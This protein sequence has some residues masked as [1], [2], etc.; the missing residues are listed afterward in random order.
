M[1]ENIKARGI[2][3][4]DMEMGKR[5]AGGVSHVTGIFNV[6]LPKREKHTEVLAALAVL[7]GIVAIE[8][9]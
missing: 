7:P 5:E 9:V 2:Y 6:R 8:E 4:Y 3:L 1:S